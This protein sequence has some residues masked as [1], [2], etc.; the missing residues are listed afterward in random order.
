MWW[1]K[2]E[3]HYLY[4]T[5]E[6]L[7]IVMAGLSHCKNKLI[8]EGRY[9]D[10]IDDNVIDGISGKLERARAEFADTEAQMENAKTGMNAPFAKETELKEK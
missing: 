10:C 3:K 2:K 7:Q 9:T 6:E 1:K 4:L 5:Y 8:R